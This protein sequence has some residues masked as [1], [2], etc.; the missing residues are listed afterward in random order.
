MSLFWVQMI[1]IELRMNLLLIEASE[2]VI[3]VLMVEKTAQTA[4]LLILKSWRS[5]EAVEGRREQ[6]EEHSKPCGCA[7]STVIE[8][9][10]GQFMMS[11]SL[12]TLERPLALTVML[13]RARRSPQ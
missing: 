9:V 8:S 3:L 2:V 4:Y 7:L 6:L 13:A 10:A 12:M 1:V 5:N 11:A